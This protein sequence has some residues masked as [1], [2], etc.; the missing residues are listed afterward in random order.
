MQRCEDA[1]ALRGGIRVLATK[2]VAL[3]P[4]IRRVRGV[5]GSESDR[6]AGA[7]MVANIRHARR[8]M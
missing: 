1:V 4:C 2:A 5:A 7:P 8:R 3:N 6:A